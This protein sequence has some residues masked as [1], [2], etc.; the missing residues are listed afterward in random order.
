MVSCPKVLLLQPLWPCCDVTLRVWKWSRL[1]HP[2]QTFH[3]ELGVTVGIREFS[4]GLR[5]KIRL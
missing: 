5:E 3:F 4:F 1:F 2:C